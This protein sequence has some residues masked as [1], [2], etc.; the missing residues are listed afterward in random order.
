ML[1]LGI[2]WLLSWGVS[3]SKRYT[4]ASYNQTLPLCSLPKRIWGLWNS[5]FSFRICWKGRFKK[6]NVW[7]EEEKLTLWNQKNS[8][9]YFVNWL[10]T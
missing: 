9:G 3:N 1:K 10:G 7:K 6:G 4:V 5:L 2:K 8:I